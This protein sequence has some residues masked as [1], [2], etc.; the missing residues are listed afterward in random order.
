[1]PA[2]NILFLYTFQSIFKKKHYIV[3]ITDIFSY[4]LKKNIILNITQ[5][6]NV[7]DS[8][9][10]SQLISNKKAIHV[11][12]GFIYGAPGKTRTSGTRFRKP[13]LYPP[14]LQGHVYRENGKLRRF[15]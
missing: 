5:H 6:D 13:L 2:F 11:T 9:Q 4:S 14:E 1:M 10:I 3:K 7:I 12:D 15:A 8:D